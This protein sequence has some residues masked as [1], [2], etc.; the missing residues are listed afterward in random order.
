MKEEKN[1]KKILQVAF[2]AL[3]ILFLL[4]VTYFIWNYVKF[5]KEP[6]Y[7]EVHD[8]EKVLNFIK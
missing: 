4:S 7:I 3:I 8:D 5:Q 2:S 1:I 6:T